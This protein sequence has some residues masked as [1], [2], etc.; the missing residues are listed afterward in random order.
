MAIRKFV[1]Y[2]LIQFFNISNSLKL[3]GNGRI[4][5]SQFMCNLTNSYTWNSL[6]LNSWFI[7]ING[8]LWRTTWLIFKTKQMPHWYCELLPLLYVKFQFILKNQKHSVTF[9][10]SLINCSIYLSPV[11]NSSSCRS[12][13]Y[14]TLFWSQQHGSSKDAYSAL[15][16]MLKSM[17]TI[18]LV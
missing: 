12:S 8:F 4:I 2:Q 10:F 7:T 14:T 17:A 15:V 13:Q 3:S 1:R 18:D 11:I 16:L 9:H 5:N 6:N